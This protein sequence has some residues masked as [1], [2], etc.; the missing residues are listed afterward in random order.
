MNGFLLISIAS[1]IFVVV[2]GISFVVSNIKKYNEEQRQKKKILQ[3]KM[4]LN[5]MKI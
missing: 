3:M 5:L 4:D 1:S 2:F